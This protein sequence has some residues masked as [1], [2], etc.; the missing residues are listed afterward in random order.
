MRTVGGEAS[1]KMGSGQTLIMTPFIYYLVER[2]RECVFQ[3]SSASSKLGELGQL[4]LLP[5]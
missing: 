2:A 5:P 3:S 1:D 4:I